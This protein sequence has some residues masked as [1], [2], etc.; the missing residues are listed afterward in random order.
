MQ[1][2]GQ[3][4][5]LTDNKI[6]REDGDKIPFGKISYL[7][8]DRRQKRGDVNLEEDRQTDKFGGIFESVVVQGDT[9]DKIGKAG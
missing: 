2:I 7:W 1:S 5:T 6:S 4:A 8:V 9:T 3:T